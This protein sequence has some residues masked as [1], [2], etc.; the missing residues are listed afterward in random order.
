MDQGDGSV[1]TALAEL[2]LQPAFYPYLELHKGRRKPTPHDDLPTSIHLYSTW[3]S[4][5]S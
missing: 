2:A 1:G 4:S 3:L 5:D